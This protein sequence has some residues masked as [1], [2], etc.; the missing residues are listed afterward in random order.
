MSTPWTAE[1]TAPRTWP[2][3]FRGAAALLH[4]DFCPW[5]NKY[6]YWL[7][8]PIGWFVVGAASACLVAVFLAPHA[9]ILFGSITA[10]ALLGVAWPALAMRGA[11]ATI[12][13]PS[14]RCRE[15]ERIEVRLTVQNRWPWPLWGLS[16]EKGFLADDEAPGQESPVVALARVP[17]WSRC[18]FTFPFHP[19]L[20]GVYP[21]RVP[22][23]ATGFPFGIWRAHRPIRI[24]RS[25]I[26]WPQTTSLTSIPDLGGSIADVIGMLFDRPGTEGDVTGVR[27]FRQGDRLR[28]IHWAQT[29][30]RDSFIV[31]ERQAA[32][33]RLVLLAVDE[34]AWK[35]NRWLRE[36]AIRV[37]AS[38]AR[39]FHA[40][41]AQVRFV[42]GAL[43]LRLEPGPAGL[44][45]LL[46][47]LAQAPV[48][49]ADTALRIDL[50]DRDTFFLVVTSSD[51][52]GAW[53]AGA[54]ARN[55]VR[56]VLLDEQRATVD[57]GPKRRNGAWIALHGTDNDADLLHRQWE[58]AC[59]D[60][61]PG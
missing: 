7:K 8:Q 49:P 14:R 47:G 58:R 37:A 16:V 35:D 56:W 45:R 41:H 46:D 15:T 17:G 39:E 26:V 13:F 19:P 20:R 5:A 55:S 18:E 2:E 12:A 30:R 38:M 44:Q 11:V 33:R 51:R 36:R 27:P 32:A 42:M 21:H 23:L 40:H 34:G 10:V 31:S 9:W 25:L 22:E 24:E 57:A 53:S 6:V 50:Q 59:H 54:V 60:S 43:D 29:A 4:W 52:Q 48:E 1:R 3:L 28:S 61:V